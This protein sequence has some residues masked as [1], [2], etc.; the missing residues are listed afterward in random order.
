MSHISLRSANMGP[1]GRANNQHPPDFRVSGKEKRF[2][3]SRL[4]TLLVTRAIFLP[5]LRM[6]FFVANHCPQCLRGAPRFSF[7][8]VCKAMGSAK[9]IKHFCRDSQQ[10]R[11]SGPCHSCVKPLIA[12]LRPSICTKPGASVIAMETKA[13]AHAVNSGLIGD[14]YHPIFEK[15]GADVGSVSSWEERHL[16]QFMQYPDAVAY[17]KMTK[18]Q[19][20]AEHVI[21]D[22][23]LFPQEFSY[24]EPGVPT[25][26][27]STRFLGAWIFQKFRQS[28]QLRAKQRAN[29]ASSMMWA[30]QRLALSGWQ[31]ME[32]TPQVS[33]LGTDLRIEHGMQFSLAS[34]AP[35]YPDIY[36]EWNRLAQDAVTCSLPRLVDPT[37]V[38]LGDFLSMLEARMHYCDDL[39]PGHWMSTLRTEVLFVMAYS[40]EVAIHSMITGDDVP[41][42]CKVAVPL[43]AKSQRKLQRMGRLA[44]KQLVEKMIKSAGSGEQ[45]CRLLCER[46]GSAAVVRNVRNKLYAAATREAFS[47][48]S[49]GHVNHDEGSYAGLS[50]NIAVLT[51]VSAY[52]AYHLRPSVL[53]QQSTIA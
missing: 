38:F 2:S 47:R 43:R 1:T 29:L 26:Q 23:R 40:V 4:P 11:F 10:Y 51:D 44:K 45:V 24:G 6:P 49:F 13:V 39:P 52:H 21:E 50:V 9:T 30:Y 17:R 25:P 42:N 33:V 27:V 19:R 37:N 20:Y 12:Q 35:H 14:T 32:E 22:W 53:N 46:H 34:L 31:L 36:A 18:Q 8:L 15:P 41:E 5:F 48:V 3:Y 16:L 7:A 28:L